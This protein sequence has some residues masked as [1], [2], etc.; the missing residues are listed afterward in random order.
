MADW[1]ST[2]MLNFQNQVIHAGGTGSLLW[3]YGNMGGTTFGVAG[4]WPANNLALYI[5]FLVEQT[6]TAYKMAFEVGAQAGNYDVG[7]YSEGGVRLVSK[8]STAVPGA[9]LAVV[10]ITDTLLTPG[11]YYMAMNVDTTTTLTIQRIVAPASIF[12][13]LAGM[14]QQAVGAVTLPNPATFANPGQAYVPSVAV[15]CRSVI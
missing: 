13:Q 1:P 5:P 7:I 6:C 15:A 4:A 10:D 14:Q 8:G 3:D 11:V 9:G 12:L 2:P